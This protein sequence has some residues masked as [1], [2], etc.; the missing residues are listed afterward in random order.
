[1]AD[2]RNLFFSRMNF[3]GLRSPLGTPNYNFVAVAAAVCGQQL[4]VI[5]GLSFRHLNR[6]RGFSSAWLSSPLS[7]QL[8]DILFAVFLCVRHVSKKHM[9]HWARGDCWYF[10][11]RRLM[12]IHF[13]RIC[14]CVE[15]RYRQ[16]K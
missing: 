12:S 15:A 1:M 11:S 16:E 14:P 2:H 13:A 7:A 6:S 4:C 10:G 9:R 3:F 8:L 5:N